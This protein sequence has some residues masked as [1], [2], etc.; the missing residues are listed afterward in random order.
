MRR[1]L[2]ILAL[3]AAMLMPLALGAQD[4][5]YIYVGN[6]TDNSTNFRSPSQT[7]FRWH[8][9]QNIYLPD[10]IGNAGT[11]TNIAWMPSES[12]G[13]PRTW[14]ILMGETAL[15]T[16]SNVEFVPASE[17]TEVFQGTV[18]AVS[19]GQWLDIELT[20]PF[21]Y[22]AA[23]NLVIAVVDE[24]GE[25][26]AN[27]RW[28]SNVSTET[29]R[30]VR[31]CS[32]DVPQNTTNQS[33]TNQYDTWL[34]NLR[35]VMLTSDVD[36]CFS[37]AAIE[38]TEI[39]A[40][41]V[42]VVVT[43]RD[44]NPAGT[45]I[46]QYKQASASWDDADAVTEVTLTSSDLEYTA[47]GLSPVTTYS[48]RVRSVCDADNLSAWRL[49]TVRTP[50]T[51]ISDIPWTDGFENSTTGTAPE[52][53]EHMTPGTSSANYLQVYSGSTHSGSNCLRF[54]YSSTIGNVIMLPDF[55][56]PI[57][58]LMITFW[59]HPESNS[60]PS[61][62]TFEVGYVTNPSDASSFVATDSWAYSNFSNS[63]Y[64]Q[65]EANFL[66]APEGAR[67]AFRHK[68]S[69]SNWY[70]QVDDITVS[71]V[72]AC[73]R[74]VIASVQSGT[75]EATVNWYSTGTEFTLFYKAASAS[76]YD[77]V[78]V[79]DDEE[80][81]SY[82]IEGLNNASLYIVYV[83][84]TCDDASL[85]CQPY[86]FSTNC[87][88][89][90]TLPWHE[91]FDYYDSYFTSYTGGLNGVTAFP[92]WDFIAAGSGAKLSLTNTN[93][94]YSTSGY[95]L[96]FYPGT[97]GVGNIVV[98]PPFDTPISELELSFMTRPEGTSSSSGSIDVG[99]ITDAGNAS[100]FVAVDHYNYTDFSDAYAEVFATFAA[101]PDGARIAVRHNSAA[102]NYYW[103]IDE[104]DVHLLPTCERPT[105]T[106][107]SVGTTTASLT[108]AD[109]SDAGSYAIVIAGMD[110]IFTT[111]AEVTITDLS[112]ATAYTATVHTV[113]SDGLS[114]GRTVTFRTGCS[115]ISQLP[116]HDNFDSYTD[117][118]VGYTSGLNNA[119]MIPCWD[120][121]PAASGAKMSLTNN[122]Y[123]YGTSGFSL[124]FYPGSTGV[125]NIIVLP[126]FEQ[127]ISGLELS[128][129]TRPEG[130]S[131][132]SGSID[133]GYMTN[134]AVASSFVAVD[135]YNYT[136]FNDAYDEIF[137]T[138]AGAPDGARIAIRHN[139][140]A[141]NYYWF[142]DEIDVHLIPSCS[143]PAAS[144]TSLTATSATFA[145]VD[146]NESG[147]Y[148]I[149][150][151]G[152][153]TLSVSG[154]EATV[155]DLNPATEYTAHF[156]TDCGDGSLSRSYTLT[157]T[158]PCEAEEFPWHFDQAAMLA[159]Q[160]PGF[161]SCW[162]WESFY[163]SSTSGVGYVYSNTAGSEFRLPPVD[164][165]LSTAQL[166]T[167]IAT[168]ASN[169]S[170][171]VGV[172]EGSNTV[173]VDTINVDQTASA[174]TGVVYEIS[175]ANYTGSGN[176]VVVG[177]LT[178][179]T[180]Y[181][182]DF[183]VEPITSCPAV[184]N[185]SV[186]DI[187]S[188]GATISWQASDD[189]TQWLVSVDGGDYEL[190]S[191]T[192]HTVTG[193]SAN[194]DH[195]VEVRARCSESDTSSARTATFHTNCGAI[196]TLP[197]SENF[198]G[199]TTGQGSA[200]PCFDILFGTDGNWNTSATNCVYAASTGNPTPGAIIFGAIN[201]TSYGYGTG[202]GFLILPPFAV[203]GDVVFAFDA[204]MYGNSTNHTLSVG[205]MTDVTDGSTFVELGTQPANYSSGTWFRD[206]VLV[207][208]YDPDVHG[209]LA[210]RYHYGVSND[211]YFCYVDNLT[212]SYSTGEVP[213]TPPTPDPCDAPTAVN[214]TVTESSVT[215]TWTATGDCQVALVSGN[216][217]SE[218]AASSIVDVAAGTGSYT[219]DAQPA[220]T[221]TV[222]VRQV[223]TESNS[224]WVTRTVTTDEQVGISNFEIQNSEFELYPNPAS[225]VVTI[226]V[227]NLEIQNSKFEIVSLS[228]QVVDQFE[229]HNSKFTIDLTSLPA[230]AYFVR[231]TG[232]QQTAVRKLIVK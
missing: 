61:C 169:A 197:W 60:N 231:L 44:D 30:Q 70:W 145:I 204:Y 174:T 33:G 191:A 153:D 72:P 227:N 168:T 172:R 181:H 121:L 96:L 195:T 223:C 208:G 102:S 170:I 140:A 69:S 47:T 232:Q 118:Y 52:C 126:E 15:G 127:A 86:S 219:F 160:T 97:S 211:Y 18:T 87:E 148:K 199:L 91:N 8:Y 92:C 171:R 129:M 100:T 134:P 67:I 221:Y 6:G 179:N 53:W 151:D 135:H 213:P 75:N 59:H 122:S 41:E 214:A 43:E 206:S 31:W 190:V 28:Y 226:S 119:T 34:P 163:R 164:V 112:P 40:T 155:T 132:S 38:A 157:F 78:E 10:E 26:G 85:D 46:L 24:T 99:Y 229:I 29:E 192:T 81:H 200:I 205:Y 71:E 105:V 49:M 101:A 220:T 3:V 77:S 66:S 68:G 210:L 186:S 4:V 58:E 79:S 16:L 123:R 55:E 217:W 36:V 98:L 42:T 209:R 215:L 111:D 116:W 94:R 107:D 12:F 2:S 5:D 207:S 177:N 1:K 150:I 110:T 39:S 222:G 218:P 89:I 120:F 84:A 113:C 74:P 9:A 156:F 158:T 57:S 133:V 182:L 21:T 175:L 106:V 185:I 131:S 108:I 124:L 196:T 212:V 224:D 167:T 62:G 162:D 23:A 142:F 54:N 184:S 143:R 11:I 35:L 125:G 180:V 194:S 228:G 17:L 159:V 149:A 63:S 103:F 136:D 202:D 20:T 93:Y 216:S 45:Y 173:W 203:S 73:T 114:T 152:M 189:Q 37:P 183:H 187:T 130:T 166:R 147:N 50:C 48:F 88:S 201:E 19:G 193:L 82:T 13:A 65:D 22:S 141:S 165:D 146:P 198:N 95:S 25:M 154:T 230:G 137:A 90:G 144:V 83:R 139:S 117:L 56:Q 27:I 161:S 115:V 80:T 51:A 178:S 188:D 138:F 176:R 14:R 64:R 109:L 32:D 76:E 7:N 225:K 128:F 104:V